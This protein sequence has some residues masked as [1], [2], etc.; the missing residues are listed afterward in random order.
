MLGAIIIAGFAEEVSEDALALSSSVRSNPDGANTCFA[1]TQVLGCSTI[2]RTVEY[3]RRSGVDEVSVF[4]N[5]RGASRGSDDTQAPYPDEQAWKNAATQLRRYQ[6]DGCEAVLVTRTGAYIECDLARLL[7]QHHE[8]GEPITRTFDKEGALDLWIVDPNRLDDSGELLATLRAAQTA[9]CE[10]GGYV[11]RLLGAGDLRRLAADILSSRCRVRPHAAEMRPGVWMEEGAQVERG[12]RVVAPA[13][14]GRGVT[15][16]DECLITRGSN[17]ESNSLID[18]GTVIEDSSILP[19]TY[20]GIGLDL[21][22]SVVDGSEVLNLQHGVRL[23]IT[24]PVVVRR[25]APHRNS[26]NGVELSE[27]ILS[28]R[29]Q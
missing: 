17:V 1:A 23:R 18:F 6:E 15:I 29:G 28:A 11:N 7:E 8:Y 22:H 21:S 20:V 10:V 12:A 19:D 26:Q 13:Y 5:R 24:D 4:G 27:V 3:L 9:D 25:N 14:I 2:V 16:A